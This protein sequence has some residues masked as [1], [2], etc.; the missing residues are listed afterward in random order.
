M[1]AIRQL[2]VAPRHCAVHDTRRRSRTHVG[3]HLVSFLNELRHRSRCRRTRAMRASDSRFPATRGETDTSREID[4]AR[5]V[6]T[7]ES[8]LNRRWHAPVNLCS[9]PAGFL[10]RGRCPDYE[11]PLFFLIRTQVTG[12]IY[13]FIFALLDVIFSWICV[14]DKNT[15]PPGK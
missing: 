1:F 14:L 5:Q 13:N 15:F 8:R 4:H 9:E 11:T 3:H 7:V 2:K 12:L 6:E 10:L